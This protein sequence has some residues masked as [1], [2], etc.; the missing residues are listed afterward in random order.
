MSASAVLV[1]LGVSAFTFAIS[2]RASKDA[3]PSTLVGSRLTQADDFEQ[4]VERQLR[5]KHIPGAVVVV[6]KN[7]QIV[8]QRAFGVANIE[9]NVPAKIDDVYPIASI[10]K[11]FAATGIFLLIQDGSLHLDDKISRLL[12]DLPREWNEVTVLD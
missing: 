10:T 3:V 9:L 2:A 5:E 6:L 11:I 7:G 1:L 12:P 4:D 8:K